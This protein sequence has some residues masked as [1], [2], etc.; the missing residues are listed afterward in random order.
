MKSLNKLKFLFFTT[1]IIASFSSCSNS[2]KL[3]RDMST[4]EQ[5]KHVIEQIISYMDTLND[6]GK[7]TYY[8][9]YNREFTTPNNR[10]NGAYDNTHIVEGDSLLAETSF[11]TSNSS[12]RYKKTQK[13]GELNYIGI[14]FNINEY[15]KIKDHVY[16]VS[17][18][19]DGKEQFFYNKNE[20]LIN[21]DSLYI[22]ITLQ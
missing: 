17:F 13:Y 2:P 7:Y 21:I 10:T 14:S 4:S 16:Y 12:D 15:G 8:M 22:P 9:A 18:I 19:N 5:R 1:T 3:L 11:F 6:N 20:Y